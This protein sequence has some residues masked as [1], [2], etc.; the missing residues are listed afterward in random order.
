MPE[1][2]MGSDYRIHRRWWSAERVWLNTLYDE[3]RMRHGS[4]IVV[5]QSSQPKLKDQAKWRPDERV[6]RVA[7]GSPKQRPRTWEWMTETL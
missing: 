7:Y 5:D 3:E 1:H 4:A 2:F 6:E